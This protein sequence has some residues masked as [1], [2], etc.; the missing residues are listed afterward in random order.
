MKLNF[1]MAFSI[2]KKKKAV[3]LSCTI[4]DDKTK[5]TNEESLEKH[6]SL[7]ICESCYDDEEEEISLFH[8]KC[9]VEKHKHYKSK[10]KKQHTESAREFSTDELKDK[11][12]EDRKKVLKDMVGKVA[13]WPSGDTALTTFGNGIVCTSMLAAR[14]LKN[15]TALLDELATTGSSIGTGASIAIGA[16][17]SVAAATIE[18]GYYAAKWCN[19]TITSH[20]FKG[21][22]I[23]AAVG[24]ISAGVI[25]AL[26]AFLGSL[27]LPGLGTMIGGIIGGL[28]GAVVSYGA[29]KHVEWGFDWDEDRK[30][31][32]IVVEAFHYLELPKYSLI[33]DSI[34]R[35]CYRK[36]ALQCHPNSQ[37]VVAMDPLEK[38]TA[39]VEWE[40]LEHS[41]DVALGYYKDEQYFSRSCKKRIRDLYNPNNRSSVTFELLR[42]N[43]TQNRNSGNSKAILM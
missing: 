20:D 34:V 37:R 3:N 6:K 4:C 18:I 38:A 2:T 7:T 43:L 35:S 19:G 23:Q 1:S 8:E 40:L 33:D 25:G 16:G 41:K 26:G 30:R 9:F 21:K 39:K 42:A 13:I 12:E 29:R 28:I 15:G 27:V 32:D 22:A 11:S 17:I 10:D 24:N 31:A 14:S 36:K 5:F